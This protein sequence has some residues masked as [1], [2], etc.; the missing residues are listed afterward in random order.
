[1]EHCDAHEVLKHN[2]IKMTRQRIEVLELIIEL[3]T[4]FSA[5]ILHERLQDHMDL[6]TI[7]RILNLFKEKKI[8]REVLSDKEE[9]IFER[10][11]IHNPVHPHFYCNNCKQLFCL[12]ELPEEI[13]NLILG[14]YK[15]FQIE[16]ISLQLSGICNKCK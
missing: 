13:R 6:V 15:E 3:Q 12:D 16:D 10:A 1:M 9:R 5:S 7:Y 4:T 14:E 8:I 11:C 2:K